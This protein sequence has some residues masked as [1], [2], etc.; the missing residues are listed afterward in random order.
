MHREIK[1]AEDGNSK[2][3]AE[4]D[5]Q[6]TKSAKAIRLLREVTTLLSEEEAKETLGAEETT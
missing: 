6:A 5:D 2:R 1:M 4:G 3:R